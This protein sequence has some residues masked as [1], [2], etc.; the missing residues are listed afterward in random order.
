[1]LG[2]IRQISALAAILAA[3]V[4]LPSTAAGQDARGTSS[5][6]L[7]AAERLEAQAAQPNTLARH[8]VDAGDALVQAAK[9]RPATDP[10]ALDDLMGAA[11]AYRVAGR[12]TA[13][14]RTVLDAARQAVRQGDVDRAAHAY[15]AAGSLS[16]ERREEE[17]ARTCFERAGRLAASPQLT[18]SQKRTLVALY[19]N[20]RGAADQK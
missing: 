16:L 12:L 20:S 5:L 15:L 2:T 19:L 8:W 11:S 4:V 3:G 9:L 18:D 6:D 17:A 7:A 1:M 14:R 10:R 13:A